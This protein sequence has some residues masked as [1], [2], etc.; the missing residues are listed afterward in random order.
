MKDTGNYLGIIWNKIA[1]YLACHNDTYI[2]MLSLNLKLRLSV[3]DKCLA[4]QISRIKSPC[5][6]I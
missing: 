4:N 3:I 5:S 6:E 2:R 1:N